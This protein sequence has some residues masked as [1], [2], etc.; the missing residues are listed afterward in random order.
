[1]ERIFMTPI[2]WIRHIAV[3]LVSLLFLAFGVY[4]LL[5]SYGMKNPHEFI[6]TFF[7]SNLIIL[8]SLVGLL[9]PLLKIFLHLKSLK[10]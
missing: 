1:M 4:L 10:A 9:H 6:M 8:I 3:A 5:S 7:A 2:F